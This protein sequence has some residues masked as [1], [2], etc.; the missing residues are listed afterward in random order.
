LKTVGPESCVLFLTP[1]AA[2]VVVLREIGGP[3]R[4]SNRLL[5]PGLAEN[6][7][8]SV[9][10]GENMEDRTDAAITLILRDFPRKAAKE[11]GRRGN[12]FSSNQ[13]DSPG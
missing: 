13:N 9:Q 3:L 12:A 4:P 8:V 1:A 7:V 2:L 10:G 11:W 6:T 5:H